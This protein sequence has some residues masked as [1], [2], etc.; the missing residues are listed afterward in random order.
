MMPVTVEGVPPGVGVSVDACRTPQRETRQGR[1]QRQP[2]GTTSTA[3]TRAI[4]R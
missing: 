4:V 1:F 2:Q 3:T